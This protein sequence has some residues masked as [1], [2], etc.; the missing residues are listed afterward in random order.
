MPGAFPE[1]ES[2]SSIHEPFVD[3]LPLSVVA[4]PVEAPLPSL[5]SL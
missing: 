5:T 2:A 3:E 1:E 4:E